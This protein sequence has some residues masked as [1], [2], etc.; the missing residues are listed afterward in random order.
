MEGLEKNIDVAAEYNPNMNSK[1]YRYANL[2]DAIM[3]SG[4]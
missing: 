1:S 4:R 2:V 3:Q